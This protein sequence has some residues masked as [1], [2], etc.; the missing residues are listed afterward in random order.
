M[1]LAEMQQ[2]LR[3][4]WP[5]VLVGCALTVNLFLVTMRVVPLHYSAE[6]EILLL[7][8]AS[9]VGVGGNPY[10]T[11]GG[12]GPIGDVLAKSL[13]DATSQQ[14]LKEAGVTG[15]YQVA[16]DTASAAPLVLVTL[17]EESPEAALMSLAL[18]L[19]RAPGAL[20][21]LQRQ[22]RV[23]G[24]ALITATV[25][26]RTSR[27]LVVR[28]PQIRA[29]LVTTVG[30]L[31]MTLMGTGAIDALLLRR[32]RSRAESQRLEAPGLAYL[33]STSPATGSEWPSLTESVPSSKSPHELT[34]PAQGQAIASHESK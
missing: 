7:P 20:E 1:F 11:L 4:R 3:R 16:A 10:L 21:A 14:K 12:L 8:P 9:V 5:L 15:T 18:I 17:E 19:E 27:P 34:N 28:K 25:L 23:R 2:V 29:L 33:S 26:T 32:R 13:T 22:T 30:G 31:G 6:A 24:N